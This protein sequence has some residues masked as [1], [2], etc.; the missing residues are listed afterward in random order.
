MK[1]TDLSVLEKVVSALQP[2]EFHNQL[3]QPYGNLKKSM[4]DKIKQYLFMNRYYLPKMI[5]KLIRI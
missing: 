2:M 1:D 4:T 3:L 5:K